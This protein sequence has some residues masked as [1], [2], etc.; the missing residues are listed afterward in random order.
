M[1]K[2]DEPPRDERR[3]VPLDSVLGHENVR[4]YLRRAIAEGRLPQSIL[5]AGP[6][7]VGKRTTAWALIR[8]LVVLGCRDP[9][10]AIKRL[11]RGRHLDVHLCAESEQSGQ[12]K[13]EEIRAADDAVS[14]A[15]FECDHKVVFIPYAERMNT[16]T[17]NCLLKLLEEPPRHV[18]VV[19]TAADPATLLPT[20]R[21]RCTI[22]PLEGV[23]REAVA[24]WLRERT[25]APR[26]RVEVAARICEGRPGFALSLLKGGALEV[27][28]GALRELENIKEDG[29]V[30]VFGA[31]ERLSSLAAELDA[32]LAALLL[33]L[34]DALVASLGAGEPVCSDL[35]GGIRRLAS[36][37]PPDR[38][39]DAA[40]AVEEWTGRGRRFYAPGARLHFLEKLAVEVGRSL[41]VAR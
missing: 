38:I 21:S 22:L 8:E 36:G 30:C 40:A 34:R 16:A 9:E 25:D 41:R 26:D 2:S 4:A 7:G 14:R 20:I 33:V 3:E 27:R 17:A 29:F 24:G 39:L 35:E 31:A 32:V 15:P 1:A 19:A 37:I 28:A 5:F 11:L 23:P 13:I 10:R 12:I 18:F 6:P